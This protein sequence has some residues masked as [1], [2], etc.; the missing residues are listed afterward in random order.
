MLRGSVQGGWWVLWWQIGVTHFAPP[1]QDTSRYMGIM[2]FLNGRDSDRGLGRWHGTGGLA[3]Q[4][5]TLALD[6]RAGSDHLR[7]VL[8]V[9]GR[10]RAK[11]NV[12][13]KPSPSSRPSSTTGRRHRR[14]SETTHWPLRAWLPGFLSWTHPR[15]HDTIELGITPNHVYIDHCLP[16]LLAI[17]SD[18]A[19]MRTR[20]DAGTCC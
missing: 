17:E 7:A 6:R 11:T 8:A 2:V 3:I 18:R 12:A 14:E 19:I 15:R 4:A 5:R 16:G 9:A 13:R 10:P 1:G 20:L